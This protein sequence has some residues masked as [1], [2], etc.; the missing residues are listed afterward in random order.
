MSNLVGQDGAEQT[1]VW[2]LAMGRDSILVDPIRPVLSVV[3]R[4]P[5]VGFGE[6]PLV[7]PNGAP[8]ASVVID[9]VS[10]ECSKTMQERAVV[11]DDDADAL[12]MKP[13]QSSEGV[14]NKSVPRRTDELAYANRFAGRRS[15]FWMEDAEAV[16]TLDIVDGSTDRD[17][18]EQIAVVAVVSIAAVRIN[19]RLGPG[20]GEV[21]GEVVIA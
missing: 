21:V 16:D 10:T 12:Q 5:S 4:G 8:V 3:A 18:L 13:R 14:F 2:L 9:I 19:I 20:G 6:Q 11:D 15:C 7:E 1:M 17:P